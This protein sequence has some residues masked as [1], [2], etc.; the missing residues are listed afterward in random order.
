MFR[1][2]GQFFNAFFTLFYMVD[3]AAQAGA[4]LAEI[5]EE[6]AAGLKVQMS[7]ER[8]ARL[9]ALTER[10]KPKA[11]PALEAAA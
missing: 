4:H 2:I 6:E 3:K 5:A 11:T 9:V 10:L 1:A 8:E 7:T